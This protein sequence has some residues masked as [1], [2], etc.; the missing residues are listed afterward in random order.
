MSIA[1]LHYSLM[2]GCMESQDEKYKLQHAFDEHAGIVKTV[3]LRGDQAAS[4]SFD[5]SIK[6][7]DMQQL[8]CK[9]TLKGHTGAVMS[10]A[11]GNNTIISGSSDSTVRVWDP[12][13]EHGKEQLKY[14][15][16]TKTFPV[17]TVIAYEDYIAS[18]ATDCTM[19]LWDIRSSRCLEML[20]LQEKGHYI[21]SIARCGDIM[22]IG[23]P[24]TPI[25]AFNIP[26]HTQEICAATLDGHT[27]SVRSVAHDAGSQQ[28]VSG[29]SDATVKVW[30]V[31]NQEC[32]KT[33][34]GH[35]KPVTSVATG[36]DNTILSGSWDYN[37]N[38]WDKNTDDLVQSL[39]HKAEV[40]T[41]IGNNEYI[42]SGSGNNVNI[43]K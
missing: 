33:Y 15:G 13:S 43:W 14:K 25:V 23:S 1:L 7:W 10:V 32:E 6:I 12:R 21:W 20:R 3:A 34:K 41:V 27:G 30:N 38:V 36:P 4:G 8:R 16:H 37:L 11:Y 35:S 29:S 40:L 9:E 22:Y 19:R 31:D 28:L 5:K 39:V 42:V 26:L 18:G 2:I 24:F 17:C